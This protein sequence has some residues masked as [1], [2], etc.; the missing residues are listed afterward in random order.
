V[1][2]LKDGKLVYMLERQRIE[3]RDAASIAQELR[4]AFDQ[5]CGREMKQP[6]KVF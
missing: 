1:A 3:N 5:H 6:L 4:A 2:L